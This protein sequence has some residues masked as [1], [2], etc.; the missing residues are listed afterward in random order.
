MKYN[1][2]SLKNYALWYYFKYFPSLKKLQ[3]KLM[4]KLP[5]EEICE[6]VMKNISHLINEKQV[7]GDKIRLYLMRN[8]N[9]NYIKSKLILA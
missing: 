4:E 3:S 9:L 5:D 1:Y 8:K 6:K 7:I 2:E